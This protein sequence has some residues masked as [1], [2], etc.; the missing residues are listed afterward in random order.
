MLLT[1][2]TIKYE[3]R[4]EK[5]LFRGLCRLDRQLDRLVF[6]IG[7]LFFFRGVGMFRG[8]V[9]SGKETLKM[10]MYGK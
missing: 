9:F 4:S 5:T 1:E 2:K 7:L 8:T 10:I 6:S 3:P